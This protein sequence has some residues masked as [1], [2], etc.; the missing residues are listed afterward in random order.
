MWYGIKQPILDRAF[1]V[2]SKEDENY[3]FELSYALYSRDKT[4]FSSVLN[5]YQITWLLVDKNVISPS[6]PKALFFRPLQDM[7][8]EIPTITKAKT[9][10]N[11]DVYKVTLRPNPKDYI[12][13]TSNLP[14]LNIYT[15]SERDQAYFDHTNYISTN[16]QQPITNDYFYPFRTLFS[17][18]LQKDIS[19]STKEGYDD[20]AFSA[21]IPPSTKQTTLTLPSLLQAETLL[22]VDLVIHKNNN[23]TLLS[24]K[25]QT[26]EIFLDG[27]NIS[28]TTTEQTLFTISPNTR[29]PLTLNVNGIATYTIRD[30]NEY[31]QRTFITTKTDNIFVL[32]N[33]DGTK[34]QSQTIPTTFLTKE[35]SLFE[36][37]LPIIPHPKPITLMVKVP[38]IHDGFIGTTIHTSDFAKAKNCDNFRDGQAFSMIEDNSIFLSAKNATA[39]ISIFLSSLPHQQGYALFI[40]QN[41]IEGRT[42]HFWILNDQEEFSPIDTYLTN[43]DNLNTFILAPQEDFDK[44]Y[45]LHFDSMS[46]GNLQ[47]R[48]TIGEISIYPIPYQ[49]LTSLIIAVDNPKREM[50][51]SLKPYI[52]HP[53]ES[54]YTVALEN[55]PPKNTTLVLSQA[56]NSGWKAYRVTNDEKKEI[57]IWQKVFPFLFGKEL[58]NH[59]LVNNWA[60]GWLLDDHV[61]P[62]TRHTF[63]IVFL[64]QYLEYLG[65]AVLFATFGWLGLTYRHKI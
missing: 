28:G 11:I 57:S 58:T 56:F 39:C 45:S 32:Q 21:T 62:A 44:G 35:P 50:P 55:N 63:V 42:L 7:I 52:T 9:F 8:K 37:V 14:K 15:S 23:Q 10:G 31:I 18:K 40:P 65:F 26:P 24:I 13:F 33:T 12:F 34:I 25:I 5:K 54:L 27:Q 36:T 47:T 6:A 19:F 16:N 4:L 51:V 41:H 59:V 22:P 46:I 64:P 2:W 53:N 1:D 61:P 48:N 17:N 38:K 20:I 49:Y 60:N 43:D 29:F 30:E 3:Y